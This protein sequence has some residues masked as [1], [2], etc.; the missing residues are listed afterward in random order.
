VKV[1]GRRVVEDA[2]SRH[3]GLKKRLD[4]WV[5]LMDHCAARH[6]IELRQLFPSADYDKNRGYTF[7]DFGGYRLRAVVQY[8][9]QICQIIALESHD[10]YDRRNKQ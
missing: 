9:V 4:A 2:G 7:F 6:I 3:P 8:R 10:Q 1:L 5:S